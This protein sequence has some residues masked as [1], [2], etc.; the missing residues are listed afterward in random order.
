[1][2]NL[3]Y[4]IMDASP[5]TVTVVMSSML[6]TPFYLL[7][8]YVFS[9]DSPRAGAR[10]GAIMASLFVAWGAVMIWF[11]LA[12][13]P[14][15]LGP[16]GNLVVPVCWLTPSL[17][18]LVFRDW[19]LAEPLSQRWLVGLQ[20]WRVIGG[21]FLIEFAR[22]NLPGAFAYPAGIGDILVGLLAIVALVKARGGAPGP[23]MIRAVLIL[24]M[25]DF[26]GAF[27]FGITS[28]EGPVRLFEH[29]A[30][31]TVLTFPV[32]MIPLFLVPYA[33]FFHT[34]SWLTLRRSLR[35]GTAEQS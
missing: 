5:V 21:V 11:C 1:M 24:G 30:R 14:G 28:S 2:N 12:G 35:G 13:V 8:T 15:R 18:L 23:T 6:V 34:L 9:G 16:L 7:A 31:S 10:K 25:L 26:A 4:Q 20:V 29:D 22:G 17:V 27:F 3:S 32:G 19:A 33:I